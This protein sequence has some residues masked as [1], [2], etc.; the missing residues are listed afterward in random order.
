MG[1]SLTTLII[2]FIFGHISPMK[3]EVRAVVDQIVFWSFLFGMAIGAI[4]SV[5]GIILGK[6]LSIF[7]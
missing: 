1:N 3:E 2:K 5:L 7:F 6:T 4:A